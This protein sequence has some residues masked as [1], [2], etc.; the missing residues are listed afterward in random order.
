MAQFVYR[1]PD[2]N[3][4]SADFQRKVARAKRR[5]AVA[6][7]IVFWAGVALLLVIGA[8]GKAMIHRL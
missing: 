1:H 2:N 6:Q 8:V 7:A 4:S 5:V 3:W